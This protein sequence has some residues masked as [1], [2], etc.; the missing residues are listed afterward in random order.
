MTTQ[1][2]D[3]TQY[4][5]E[6]LAMKHVYHLA[7]IIGPRGSGTPQEAWAAEY[8]RQE[9]ANAGLQPSLESFTGAPSAWRLYALASA[10]AL[11]AEALFLFGGQ[12]GAGLASLLMVLVSASALA[13]LTFHDNFLR[14]VLVAGST[15]P[16]L[17]R[18]EALPPTRLQ[19]QNVWAVIPASGQV[20]QRVLLIA[21]LDTCRT[22]RLFSTPRWRRLVPFMIPIGLGAIA[23][24]VALFVAGIFSDDARWRALSYVPVLVP[25]WISILAFEADYTPYSPGAND[26]A[27]GV[28]VVLNLAARLQQA[29]LHRSEAWVL[30][31]G[32]KGMGGRGT[33]DF[34][35]R[36]R[37]ELGQAASCITLEAVGRA[38][39]GPCY[40]EQE[41]LLTAVRGDAGL[42]RLAGE[43][44]ACRPELGAH[45]GSAANLYTEGRQAARAGLRV[46]SLLNIQ[47]DGTVPAWRQ[48]TDIYSTVDKAAVQNAESFVW[49]L[50][51]ALD[52]DESS[53]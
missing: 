6:T 26:N 37:G 13:E 17:L 7:E 47:A 53:A 33:A 23:L 41:K 16:A 9:L 3:D 42:L 31:S 50:L 48:A 14:R 36:H 51:H 21:H 15:L 46:L 38:G 10:L 24:L 27:S 39:P 4:D 12:V 29:P 22:P 20:E 18:R 28:G 25:W 35:A 34:L 43:L 44:A 40:L 45:S 30:C 2:T 49:E 1:H 5:A 8:A 19:S 52:E 32:G 11:M